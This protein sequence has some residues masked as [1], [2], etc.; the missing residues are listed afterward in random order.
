MTDTKPTD[1]DSGMST[2]LV[3]IIIVGS[4]FAIF[5]TAS[6][7]VVHWE[8]M[9]VAALLCS[10]VAVSLFF[11]LDLQK[12][13]LSN[14]LDSGYIGRKIIFGLALIPIAAAPFFMGILTVNMVAD[15]SPAQLE[16][17]PIV[18]MGE[19]I[20]LSGCKRCAFSSYQPPDPGTRATI[21]VTVTDLSN[22]LT[23]VSVQV[24]QRFAQ[25][26]KINDLMIVAIRKGRW[27]SVMYRRSGKS[28]S[29][30]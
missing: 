27:A 21:T 29:I 22:E 11:F 14:R 26:S 19:T 18:A 2:L 24:P 17:T 16:K 5:T 12:R 4:W 23:K 30:N 28:R 13:L 3:L 8:M 20:I 7:N 1:F 10:A 25:T 15:K 9:A 6:F